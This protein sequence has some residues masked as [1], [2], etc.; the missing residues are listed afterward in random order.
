MLKPLLKTQTINTSMGLHQDSSGPGSA[1]VPNNYANEKTRLTCI[2]HLPF[3]QEKI[4]QISC[5]PD[6]FGIHSSCCNH[7]ICFAMVNPRLTKGELS[8]RSKTLK[9]VTKGIK[10]FSFTSFAVIFMKKIGVPPYPGVG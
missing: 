2:R 6:S 8:G 5:H 3:C 4:P 1:L 7:Q 10:V 9:K